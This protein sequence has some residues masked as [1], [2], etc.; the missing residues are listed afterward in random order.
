MSA[1]GKEKYLNLIQNLNAALEIAATA[2]RTEAL[3][4]SFEHA[5]LVMDDTANQGIENLTDNIIKEKLIGTNE[6]KITYENFA[7]EKNAGLRRT[8]V[9]NNPQAGTK[10]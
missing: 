4:M 1:E 3:G 10:V 6:A 8:V 7:H 9:D 5:L 2:S